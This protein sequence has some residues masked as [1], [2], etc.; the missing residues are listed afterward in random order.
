LPNHPAEHR[1]KKIASTTFDNSSDI[2]QEID[3]GDWQRFMEALYY[4]F[5]ELQTGTILLE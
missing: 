5:F 2:Q 4:N 1:A 3:S